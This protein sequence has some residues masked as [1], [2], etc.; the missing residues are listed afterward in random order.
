MSAYDKGVTAEQKALVMADPKLRAIVLA[1]VDQSAGAR[2]C[3]PWQSW[4]N[5]Q[6]YGKYYLQ[7]KAFRR[8]F[9]AHRLVY[10]ILKQQWPV[11]PLDH[12]C[13]RRD[14]CN[15]DHLEPVT[16]RENTLRGIG[17]SAEN[18][19]KSKCINGHPLT[20]QNLS[21]IKRTGGKVDRRCRACH[22]D[23]ERGYRLKRGN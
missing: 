11:D 13:R 3:W 19:R 18:A 21:I 5:W 1:K 15:P 20:G 4:K 16:V 12:V 7:R 9:Q 6:G 10:I 14:C 23:R 17:P 8:K 2:G 22:A